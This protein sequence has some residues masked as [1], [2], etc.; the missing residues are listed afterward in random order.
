[1]ADLEQLRGELEQHYRIRG[2]AYWAERFKP[3]A[4]V[5]GLTSRFTTM[6]QYSTRDLLE[7]L[8]SQGYRT[9]M[10]LESKDHEIIPPIE[11]CRKIRD[12]DPILVTVVDHLRYEYP[13]IPKNLP[14][15]GW[16]QDPL[17]NMLCGRAGE[18]IGPLDVVCGYYKTRC[19]NEF[20]YP[21]DRF[22]PVPL[23]VSTRVFHDGPVD[24]E[25]AARHACDICFVSHASVPIEEF[26]NSALA[27]YPAG[28]QPFLAA[29]RD[30]VHRVLDED[31]DLE[32]DTAAADLVRST[33]SQ[34]GLSL[35]AEQLEHIKT[36]FAYRLFDWG[37]RQRTLAWVAD[38]ARRTGRVFK[39]YGR[40]WERHGSLAEFA[41]GPV[42]HGEPLRQAYRA[43]KLALQLIPSGFLHQRSYEVVASGCL[44]LTRYCPID[45]GGLSVE[46]F[47][48][49]RERGEKLLGAAAVLPGFERIVF[50]TQAEFEA[51]A[52][53]F[54]S[55]EGYAHGVQ[56]DL[57][58]HVLRECTYDAVMR[59]VMTAACEQLAREAD[60][61]I[62][63]GV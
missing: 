16:I 11:V 30:R 61:F 12:L 32:V 26:Y 6:L 18:C 55:D 7:A 28:Y 45:F 51:L 60:R 58:G 41:A 22:V 2:P 50:R 59:K 33:A 23:P 35:T 3:P 39:I 24:A 44:P 10:L 37:R 19:V 29:I 25:S 40:G 9:E 27:D 4:T 5:L 62:P 8:E 42:E 36:H 63:A 20:G 14:F 31:G 53:R 15:L 54:L 49:R 47:G 56:A 34:F 43:A 1:L 17:G 13:H 38:W 48:S 57:R 46:E 52:E 21:A